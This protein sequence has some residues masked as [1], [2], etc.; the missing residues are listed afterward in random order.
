MNFLLVKF[1]IF[2]VLK[3]N[4]AEAQICSLKFLLTAALQIA[5]IYRSVWEQELKLF[6]YLCYYSWW[7]VEGRNTLFW[8]LA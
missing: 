8:T 6:Y 1:I 7:V 5:T 3:W 2:E 4:P